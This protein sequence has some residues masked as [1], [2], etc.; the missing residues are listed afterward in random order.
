MNFK[1]KIFT[2]LF[3][4]INKFNHLNSRNHGHIYSIHNIIKPNSNFKLHQV[5]CLIN[6]SNKCLK[7]NLCIG[8]THNV[9]HLPLQNE[10]LLEFQFITYLWSTPWKTPICETK[11][12]KLFTWFN[13]SKITC[14][15]IITNFIKVLNNFNYFLI[16]Y[17]FQYT[18]NYRHYL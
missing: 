17:T 13:V 2:K 16:C 15:I 5:F 9:H 12:I 7:W 8:P 18:I 6:H 11:I 14:G 4:K 1:I 3:L 10:Y